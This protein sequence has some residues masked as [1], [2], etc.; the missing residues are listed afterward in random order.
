MGFCFVDSSDAAS[1]K[2]VNLGSNGLH[3][4]WIDATLHTA[5]VV[6][7]QTIW[8][9]SDDIL[10]CEAVCSERFVAETNRTVSGV[11]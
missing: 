11:F 4:C 1:A 3:V 6:N 2:I 9:C 8:N 5:Q 7:L 10:V